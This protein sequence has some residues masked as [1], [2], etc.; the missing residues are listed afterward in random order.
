MGSSVA[1]P[2]RQTVGWGAFLYSIDPKMV[3]NWFLAALLKERGRL[4]Q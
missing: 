1:P 4:S 2:Y 3:L